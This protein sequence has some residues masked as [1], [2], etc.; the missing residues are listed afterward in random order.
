MARFSYSS[1]CATPGCGVGGT[2]LGA[3]S[4]AG[5]A[6]ASGAGCW[7]S[8][9][10]VSPSLAA[11]LDASRGGKPQASGSHG[12]A[13]MLGGTEST[14]RSAQRRPATHAIVPPATHSGGRSTGEWPHQLGMAG[15]MWV[16]RYTRQRHAPMLMVS[17][18][19]ISGTRRPPDNA[20]ASGNSSAGIHRAEG[21]RDATRRFFVAL[22]S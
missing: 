18:M 22:A 2:S 14:S 5:V 21:R 1:F 13:V 10:V 16:G 17:A 3:V 9:S 19:R 8:P 12:Q 7:P 4:S 6:S 15:D 20:A 11:S